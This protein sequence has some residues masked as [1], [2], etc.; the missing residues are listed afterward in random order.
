M[1]EQEAET[2]ENEEQEKAEEGTSEDQKEVT[3]EESTE[4][5]QVRL[6]ISWTYVLSIPHLP[7]K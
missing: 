1:E 5:V 3:Q 7:F 2:G 6:S 4:P